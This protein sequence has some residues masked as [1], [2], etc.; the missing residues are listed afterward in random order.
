MVRRQQQD[1]PNNRLQGT[2]TLK[3]GSASKVL[4]RSVA[5]RKISPVPEPGVRAHRI[6][7]V[8]FQ[9]PTRGSVSRKELSLS[10]CCLACFQK[11]VHGGPQLRQ[12]TLPESSRVYMRRGGGVVSP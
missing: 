8:F 10:Q 7:W 1:T 12:S 2:G 5:L 11:A 9:H 3:G 6:F 4:F